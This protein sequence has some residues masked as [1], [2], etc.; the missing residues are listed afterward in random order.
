MAKK[1]KP[2]KSN[3]APIK[4]A[5]PV[6]RQG[7]GFWENTKWHSLII[8]FLASL[9]YCN[10][11]GHD[12]TQDDA[13]VITDNMYTQQGVKGIPGLLQY[14][15]FKGFFKVEGKDKL[16]SGGRYRPLTPIIFALEWQLFKRQKKN[17]DGT[18]AK[19]LSGNVIY[20]GNP[21]VYHITNVLFYALCC[22][23]LLWTFRALLHREPAKF[24]NGVA[25]AAAALFALHPLHTEAVANVKGADE[26]VTMLLSLLSFYLVLK[27]I[28]SKNNIQMILAGVVFFLALLAKENAI[29]FLAI[30]PI[31][32]YFAYP[33]KWKS[34]IIKLYPLAIATVLFLIRRGAVL[35]WSLGEESK[36]LMNNPY[37]KVVGNQYVPFDVGERF[38]TI[39]YT[40]GKYIQLY[41]F[42]ATLTHDYYPRAVE[43]M[44]WSNWQSILSLLIY[45]AIAFFAIRSL[46]NR[47]WIGFGLIFFLASLSIVSNVI[48]PVGT[49]MSERFMFIPSAGLSLALAVGLY[50]LLKIREKNLS[51]Y[52]GVLAI[53]LLLLGFKTVDRNKAWKDNFTLFITDIENSP[54]SAKLLNAVGAELSQRSQ[55]LADEGAKKAQLQKAIGYLQEAVKIHP[56]FE[57]AYLQLGNCYTFDGDPKAALP[58]YQKV[59]S[60]DPNDTDGTHNM[61]VALRDDRQFSAAIEQFRKLYQMGYPKADVD[62][63]IGFVHE[64]AGKHFSAS[65][66]QDRAIGHFQQALELSPEKDKLTYFMGV[67]YALKKDYATAFATLEQAIQLTKDENNKVNIYRTL[68]SMHQEAGNTAEAQRYAQ[69]VQQAGG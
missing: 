64:E 34:A 26:V 38:A 6:T 18:I 54:R 3:Q 35:G 62:Y 25:L 14:D 53:P 52:F 4:K 9:I 65:G 68:S 15:T 17:D 61:G 20:E 59:L 39:F 36:E 10:T 23:L 22:L 51:L 50:Q 31:G 60:L 7:A 44:Q 42:P 5:T 30:I 8:F 19:D 45:L 47:S 16:V 58:Y 66:D 41:L 2:K 49:N 37:L 57:N 29:T 69:L 24:R 43:I 28:R 56:N 32:V 33:E 12:F 1:N 13:I 40:L 55:D 46:R 48:F 63:K 21:L 67:A 27:S 11:L